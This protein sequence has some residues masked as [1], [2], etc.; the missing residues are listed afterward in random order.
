MSGQLPPVWEPGGS[1]C[2]LPSAHLEPS[3]EMG[4]LIGY[5]P[6]CGEV[7]GGSRGPLEGFLFSMSLP[8]AGE[9]RRWASPAACLAEPW[10][11]KINL[12]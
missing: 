6:G 3:L 2:A 1:P 4:W 12:D 7:L 9:G 5:D 11:S 10:S 8:A